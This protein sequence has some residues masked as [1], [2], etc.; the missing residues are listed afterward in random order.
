M[1]AVCSPAGTE[2]FFR[3]AGWDLSRPKPDGWQITPTAM[4]AAA[5]TGQTVLRPPLAAD[6]M[7]PEA[8]LTG[9]R[10]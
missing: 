2:K 4:A 5:A 3:A 1:L 10:H 8:F 6:E 7:I 9:H